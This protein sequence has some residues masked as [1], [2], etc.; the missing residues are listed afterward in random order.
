[1]VH[2]PRTVLACASVMVNSIASQ[3]PSG[4]T[5]HRVSSRLLMPP[6]ALALRT[7]SPTGRSSPP[8]V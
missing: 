8:A 3:K 7:A 2:V 4:C 5:K 1:M 6:A